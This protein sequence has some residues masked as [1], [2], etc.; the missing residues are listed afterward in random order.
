MSELLPIPT[1]QDIEAALA[2]KHEGISYYGW[3]AWLDD[4]VDSDER[5]PWPCT[6]D[7]LSAEADRLW[8]V[9]MTDPE[10]VEHPAYGGGVTS[11]EAAA[12]AWCNACLVDWVSKPGLSEEDD[13]VVPRDVPEDAIVPRHVPE[14][15]R[16]KVRARPVRPTLK[17]VQG[18]QDLLKS[19]KA[20]PSLKSAL[21]AERKKSASDGEFLEHLHGLLQEIIP[22]FCAT[23]TYEK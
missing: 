3:F 15:Y 17:V 20:I 21:L 13:S 10:G 5:I 23:L 9:T 16:F 19:D 12:V 6:S 14:G 22:N 1:P 18:S 2:K 4:V 7:E 8:W 11:G